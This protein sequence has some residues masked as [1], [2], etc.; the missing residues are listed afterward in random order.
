MSP[1]GK[2]T[3]L[4]ERKRSN[5][6]LS[7]ANRSFAMPSISLKTCPSIDSIQLVVGQ[8]DMDYTLKEIVEAYGYRK[9]SKIVPGGKVRQESVK[10]GIE[11]LP[12]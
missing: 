12:S 5:F 7:P 10:N 9:I 6:F 2:G 8:E 1:P 11:T 4:Q 3:V